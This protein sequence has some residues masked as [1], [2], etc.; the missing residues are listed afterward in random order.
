MFLAGPHPAS[1]LPFNRERSEFVAHIDDSGRHNSGGNAAMPA[2][3]V[4]SAN[5]Q[6]FFHARTGVTFARRLQDCRTNRE[7][8][9]LQ[10]KKVDAF[11]D[12]VSP[13]MFGADFG[14]PHV[15]SDG[16]EMFGLNECHLARATGTAVAVANNTPSEIELYRL[17]RYHRLT[18]AW[19]NAE[20]E[21][22]PRPHRRIQQLEE[23]R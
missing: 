11:H 9:S 19:P 20:P 1:P 10:G 14:S 15:A 12:D 6:N 23:Q 17:R 16:C 8:H 2:D 22:A 3:G 5:A 13:E 7:A 4:V 21:N 18:T